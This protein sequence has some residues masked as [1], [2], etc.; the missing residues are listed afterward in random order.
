MA[1]LGGE[2]DTTIHVSNKFE[3]LPEGEYEL[4]VTKS[5]MKPTSKGT[6]KILA[7]TFTVVSG[8]QARKIMMTSYNWE[9]PSP[10]AVQIGK[11]EFSDLCKAVGVLKPRDSQLVHNIPFI[12]KVTVEGEYNK[13][14]SYKRKDGQVAA[15][16]PA[17]APVAPVLS[18]GAAPWGTKG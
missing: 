16:P 14:K 18:Q 7:C 11:G 4:M 15:A 10:I 6:G 12:G 2:F 17:A 1:D 9:N 8:P 3:C 5:E 13:I